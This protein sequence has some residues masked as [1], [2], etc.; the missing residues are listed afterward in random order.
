MSQKDN[1]ADSACVIRTPNRDF[2]R[3]I[4]FVRSAWRG[5]LHRSPFL[6]RGT[7]A[8]VLLQCPG[9][10]SYGRTCL[11][12]ASPVA[13]M[14]KPELTGKKDTVIAIVHDPAIGH[15]NARAGA[16][17]GDYVYDYSRPYVRTAGG[18]GFSSIIAR[19][20][21][22]VRFGGIVRF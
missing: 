18:S 12:G 17:T 11:K 6:S 1:R 20:P 2:L 8:K 10:S 9:V 4:I 22:R 13:Y 7:P 21:W 14:I 16:V 19:Y 3:N 15:F 5:A